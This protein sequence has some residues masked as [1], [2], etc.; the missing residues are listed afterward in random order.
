MAVG[1]HA[2]TQAFWKPWGEITAFAVLWRFHCLLSPKCAERG[3][4]AKFWI[5]SSSQRCGGVT[6]GSGMT[7]SG[8]T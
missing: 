4:E 2:G 6:Q 5:F 3:A 8:E 7:L 1:E